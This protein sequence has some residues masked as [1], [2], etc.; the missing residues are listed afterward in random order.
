MWRLELQADVARI[1]WQMFRID[2]QYVRKLVPVLGTILMQ[3]LQQKQMRSDCSAASN[4]R[5][6][7]EKV[8]EIVFTITEY[9]YFEESSMMG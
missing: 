5:I 1:P 4:I 9:I 8:P 2:A 6:S 7:S 3:S